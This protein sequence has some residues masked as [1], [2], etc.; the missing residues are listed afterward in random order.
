MCY[1][2]KFAQVL[3]FSRGTLLTNGNLNKGHSLTLQF[4]LAQSGNSIIATA[5]LLKSIRKERS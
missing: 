4:Y 2:D 3:L 1:D 5:C